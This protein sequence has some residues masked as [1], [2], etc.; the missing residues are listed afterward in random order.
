MCV[1]YVN[2]SS[3]FYDVTQAGPSDPGSPAVVL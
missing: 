3:I 2:S 1:S